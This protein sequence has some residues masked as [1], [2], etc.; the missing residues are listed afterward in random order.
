MSEFTRGFIAG[1]IVAAALG[2]VLAVY[3]E[4][5]HWERMA[6]WFGRELER[7]IREDDFS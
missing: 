2:T 6:H 1:C 3:L 4:F 5:K 7:A